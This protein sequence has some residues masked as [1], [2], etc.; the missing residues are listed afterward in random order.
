MST[1]LAFSSGIDVTPAPKLSGA[2][3]H[4]QSAPNRAC[5]RAYIHLPGEVPAELAMITESNGGIGEAVWNLVG[6]VGKTSMFSCR[7]AVARMRRYRTGSRRAKH[8]GRAF[9]VVKVGRVVHASVSGQ[10]DG[11]GLECRSSSSIFCGTGK[12]LTR[13]ELTSL[14]TRSLRLSG[15]C[16]RRSVP[17]SGAAAR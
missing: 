8:L 13:A 2:A 9:D 6:R 7:R 12:G 11:T 16:E 17:R 4:E 1:G 15:L 3:D 14:S 10:P 5:S